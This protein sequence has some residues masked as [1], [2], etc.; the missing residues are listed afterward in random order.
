VEKAPEKSGCDQEYRDVK[1]KKERS[2]F[3]N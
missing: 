3:E 1:N 2:A